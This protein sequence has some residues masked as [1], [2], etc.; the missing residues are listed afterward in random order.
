MSASPGRFGGSRAQYQL[1]Q[2]LIVLNAHPINLPEVMLS[3][4]DKSVDENGKINNEGTRKL[5][6]ELLEEL[7]SWTKK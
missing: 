3:Q 6:R 7:I 5:I 1:R 4:A 2:T